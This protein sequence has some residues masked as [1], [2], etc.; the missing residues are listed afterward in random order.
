MPPIVWYGTSIQQGGVASRAGN[1]YDAI[2]SRTLQREVLNLGFANNGVMELSV[3]ELLSD[4][5][6]AAV[7]VIDCLPNMNTAQVVNRTI[8]LVQ[9]L[10]ANGHPTTPIVLAEGTPTP[11]DWLN[12]N[13]TGTWSN[14]KNAA[15]REQYNKLLAAGGAAS[16][17]LHYVSANDL[18]DFDL[19]DGSGTEGRDVNPTVCGIHSSDLGQ[20][21]IANFYAKFL[22]PIVSGQ[23]ESVRI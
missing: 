18:F 10:R 4:I 7:I 16:K 19:K 12:D 11:A 2:I 13:A 14:P 9:Y 3:G 23:V 17:N 6:D 20:Y 15:L 5:K 8:P 1:T 22:P 21:M